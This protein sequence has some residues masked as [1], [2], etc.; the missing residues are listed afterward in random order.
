MF[1]HRRY[2]EKVKW[3]KV[4]TLIHFESDTYSHPILAVDNNDDYYSVS[5][6]IHCSHH[7]GADNL[8]GTLDT[9]YPDQ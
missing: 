4:T 8:A 3:L 2:N 1:H 5:H 6:S 9:G 7:Y